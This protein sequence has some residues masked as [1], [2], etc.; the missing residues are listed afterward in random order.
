MHAICDERVP[1]KPRKEFKN[2]LFGLYNRK[3]VAKEAHVLLIKSRIKPIQTN[4]ALGLS[5]Y[6][7]RDQLNISASWL[8]SEPGG[9]YL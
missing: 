1:D 8:S 9:Y 3:I 6:N 7:R 5:K 4:S 2:S